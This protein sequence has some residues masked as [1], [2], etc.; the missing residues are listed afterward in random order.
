MPIDLANYMTGD[1]DRGAPRW[2]EI[3]WVGV[4]CLFFLPGWPWPSW[5]RV[6]LLRTFGARVGR[7]VV[8]RSQVNISF[9][10]RLTLGDHVWIGEEANLLTLAPISIGSHC[11]VSQRAFLCT[12]SHRFARDTFDLVTLPIT[13]GDSCWIA[14][15]A[16]VLPGVTFGP[17]AMC[18]AGSVV[19][20]DV[21]AGA[22]CGGNPA[23]VE[24]AASRP[25]PPAQPPAPETADTSP[26]ANAKSR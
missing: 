16:I 5:W 22:I 25:L 20:S 7:G 19:A 14:A 15:G 21:P 17:A 11:C 3:F 2:K 4:K 10:W 26:E 9:P 8:I 24:S 23:R 13:I 1:F 12:G 6:A 18:K